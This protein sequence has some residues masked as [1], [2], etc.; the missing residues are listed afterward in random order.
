MKTQ[1]RLVKLTL[2]PFLGEKQVWDYLLG[3]PLTGKWIG[4][5]SY[6]EWFDDPTRSY[7]MT[8]KFGFRGA[9]RCGRVPA[10]KF[11][12]S[13]TF[14]HEKCDTKEKWKR[15]VIWN[16]FYDYDDDQLKLIQYCTKSERAKNVIDE[17]LKIDDRITHSRS[18]TFIKNRYKRKKVKKTSIN[19]M[20]LLPIALE[21]M[22]K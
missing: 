3:L 19:Q 16:Y 17:L 9:W 20:Q 6:G 4:W 21:E 11:N 8:G 10:W 15:M 7:Y 1:N 5:D 2:N 14:A 18:Q 12:E 22:R 13:F